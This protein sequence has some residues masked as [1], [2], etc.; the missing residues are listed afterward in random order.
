VTCRERGRAVALPTPNQPRTG[1]RT[2]FDFAAI[3]IALACF[4]FLALIL[5]VLERV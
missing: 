2:M 5:Y 4:A 3:A 1:G